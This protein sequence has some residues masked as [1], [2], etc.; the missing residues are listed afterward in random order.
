MNLKTTFQNKKMFR[1]SAKRRDV[2]FRNI[3][4]EQIK[5]FKWTKVEEKYR[6]VIRYRW[7]NVTLKMSIKF[8]KWFKW[9]K[10]CL[11][12]FLTFRYE[13]YKLSN[14]FKSRFNI[15]EFRSD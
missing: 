9:H 8:K 13:L 6:D 11:S 7:E 10:R 5:S 4:E 1:F 3:G 12:I 15:F 2:R 14:K